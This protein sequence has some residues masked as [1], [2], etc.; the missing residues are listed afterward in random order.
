MIGRKG[1]R[2]A[3]AA[4]LLGLGVISSPAH[5][6]DLWLG[7]LA[8]AAGDYQTARREWAPLATSGDKVSQYKL[9]LL[10][11]RGHGVPRDPA[12]AAKWF[13]RAA[14]QGLADAQFEMGNLLLHDLFET[15]DV[16]EARR[17]Y[18]LA[19]DQGHEAAVAA[20]ERLK[21]TPNRSAIGVQDLGSDAEDDNIFTLIE[22]SGRCAKVDGRRFSIDVTVDIP[23]API[24][25]SLS[26]S[27]LTRAGPHGGGMQTIGLAVPEIEAKS[28]G[29][30]GFMDKGDHKCFWVEHVQAQVVY[31]SMK[32]FIASEYKKG[33]CPYA[34]ILR[35]EREHVAISR[36]NL[37]RFEP[38]LRSALASLSIPKAGQPLQIKADDDP[39]AQMTR[40]FNRLVSPVL[41][42]M[43]AD[44]DAAQAKI[45][46]PESYAKVRRQCRNW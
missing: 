12:K 2:T 46:T 31:Q 40:L 28:S 44:L 34:K 20:L 18:R 41:E 45:D 6:A 25:H 17:W 29:S 22:S 19:A 30:Y 24:D 23:P 39:S 11:G 16:V 38:R 42:D 36:R 26:I 27:Q 35:H 13:G 10:Y 1:I 33:S 9:G 14:D 8:F 37:A 32:I 21:Q 5:S 7:E 3:F 43:M 15:P 4:V